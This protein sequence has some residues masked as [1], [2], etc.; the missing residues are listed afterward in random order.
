MDYATEKI[1]HKC[2]ERLAAGTQ[3]ISMVCKADRYSNIDCCLSSLL[4]SNQNEK[5]S[6][7]F[8]GNVV[9]FSLFDCK[10]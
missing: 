4:R 6:I 1:V 3:V 9:G 2:Q 10:L 5:E 7:I 8:K